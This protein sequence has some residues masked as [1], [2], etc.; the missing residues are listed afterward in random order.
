M[1]TKIEILNLK[2][3]VC[4]FTF[5]YTKLKLEEMKNG[6][7]LE[8]LLGYPLAVEN[9][10]RSVKEQKLGKILEIKKNK[11]KTW[12]IIIKKVEFS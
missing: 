10:P 4:P 5:V 7:I 11:N 1:D 12:K 6:A 2:N 3:E 9:V 8:V